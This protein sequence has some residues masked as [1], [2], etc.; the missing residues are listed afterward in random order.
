MGEGDAR[1]GELGGI[2]PLS[3]I[4]TIRERMLT[5]QVPA[6]QEVFSY[7]NNFST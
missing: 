4:K 7:G 1:E 2:V 3:Q 6:H 5:F